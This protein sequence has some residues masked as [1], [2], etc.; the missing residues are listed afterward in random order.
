MN[1]PTSIFALGAVAP[2]GWRAVEGTPAARGPWEAGMAHGGAPGAL[3]VRAVEELAADAGLR[4]A[5]LHCTFLG[6][7]PVAG[8]RLRARVEK[9]GRRQRVAVAEIEAGGRVVLTARAVLLRRGAVPLP[10]GVGG[11]APVLAPVAQARPAGPWFQPEDVVAF[12]PTAMEIRGVDGRP[13]EPPGTETAWFRLRLPVVEGER[14]SPAQRAVAAADFGNGLT[15]P[16]PFA[17]YLFVNCDLFVALQREP[18]G[19]WIGLRARTEVD[20]TG[21]GVTTS[22]LH[23][24]RGRVGTAV[25]TLFVD[26]R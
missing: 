7:V 13:G 17:D 10:P 23:D 21:G 11:G 3:V 20:A 2:D 22:E 1:E 4:L 19:E 24:E 18:V 14:P 25:Q 9:P 6:P 16:V 26:R 15:E 8:L 12:A 5:S